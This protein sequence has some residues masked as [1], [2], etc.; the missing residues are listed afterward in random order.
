M[1]IL[2]G[3][4]AEEMPRGKWIRRR[5]NLNKSTNKIKKKKNP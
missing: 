4:S 3:P 2:D 1:M 5:K